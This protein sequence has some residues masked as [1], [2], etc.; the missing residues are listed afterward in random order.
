MCGT[1]PRVR[2]RAIDSRVSA[3]KKRAMIEFGSKLGSG[4]SPTGMPAI[5][6]APGPTVQVDGEMGILANHKRDCWAVRC[7]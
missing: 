1:T 6:A 7:Y 5:L 3:E 2:L 4:L